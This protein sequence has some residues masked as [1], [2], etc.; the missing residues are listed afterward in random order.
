[1]KVICFLFDPNVGGPTSRARSVSLG[2]RKREVEV[3]FALPSVNGTAIKYLQ[4]QDFR[5]IDL[6]LVK[7][8]MPSK[9]W[10]FTKFVATVPYSIFK[11]TQL[12]KNEKPDLVHVNG[13][14]DIVPAI[15][16]KLSRVPLVWHLNDMVFGAFLSRTLGKVVSMLS[17]VVVVSTERVATHYGV[18]RVQPEVLRVPV[19]IDR[20]SYI[21]IKKTAPR[22]IGILGNWN[23]LK[24]QN[25][26][27]TVIDMLLKAG[28]DVEAKMMG[29]LLDSQVNYWRPI[30]AGLKNRKLDKKI[31]VLDFVEDIPSALN[32]IDILLITSVSEAGPMSC[33]EA[34][35]AGVP[36]VT[37]DVG[38]VNHMLLPDKKEQCGFVVP[39]G[40]NKRMFECC[41]ELLTN[42][43]IYD[44]FSENSR[45]QALSYYSVDKVV[46]RTFAVYSKAINCKL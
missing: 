34:M 23:P 24:G 22:T 43:K 17:S 8:V 28:H 21:A 33:V 9:F 12:L 19:D 37:F 13:A 29:R 25:D 15:S 41:V 4:S 7:P 5:V 11:C 18:E 36:V 39:S 42:T 14:F 38:D 44:R 1:M 45:K 32:E 3:T 30:L 40:D 26:F 10:A 16:A 6:K 2:L 27:I 46:E 31:T 35:A 20:F